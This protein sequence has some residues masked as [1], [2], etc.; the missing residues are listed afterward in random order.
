MGTQDW[1]A[2]ATLLHLRKMS[3]SSDETIHMEALFELDG[4]A[5]MERASG[6]ARQCAHHPHVQNQ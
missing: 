2:L 1:D 3:E 4:V 6:Q 5:N